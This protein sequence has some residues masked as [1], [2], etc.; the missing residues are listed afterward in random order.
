MVHLKTNPVIWE[1]YNK[2][3]NQVT[4]KMRYEKK[5]YLRNKYKSAKMQ[6]DIETRN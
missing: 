2:I 4:I 5:R 1:E 6:R 3:R